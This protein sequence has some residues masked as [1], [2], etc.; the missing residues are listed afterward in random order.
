MS[1]LRLSLAGRSGGPIAL[2]NAGPIDHATG[3]LLSVAELQH[4]LRAVR[5]ETASS[6][7]TN[8][9]SAGSATGHCPPDALPRPDVVAGVDDRLPAAPLD[10]LTSVV[11]LAAHSGA[12]ASTVALAIADTAAMAGPVQ[13]VEW[14]DPGR[15]G[16]VSVATSELGVLDGGAWRRGL[17]G[18]VT[19]DRR[20]SSDASSPWPAPMQLG[21][22]RIADLGQLTARSV[23]DRLPVVVVCRASVPGIRQAEQLLATVAE[24]VAVAAVGPSRWT[25]PVRATA[26]ARMRH[27]RDAGRIISVPIDRHLEIAGLTTSPL[28]KPVLA[29]GRALLHLIDAT[30]RGAPTG[31]AQ[32]ASSTKGSAR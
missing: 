14:C 1:A 23:L 19:I 22:L 32:P 29:T 15:S 16:L 3:R 27:L 12:G 7:T 6:P 21:G 10:A 18:T 9:R 17:R 2:R 31:A 11:V 24:P 28:P 8:A 20:A 13:L 4:A 30:G 5:T 25:G 26:G